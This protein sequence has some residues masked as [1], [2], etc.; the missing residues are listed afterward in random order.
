MEQLTIFALSVSSLLS[1]V[2]WSLHERQHKK[3]R[4]EERRS[5]VANSITNAI[6]DHRRMDAKPW[7]G[8]VLNNY[9]RMQA[10]GV[11]LVT[12]VGDTDV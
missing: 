3:E 2:R 11:P 8:T 6:T 12:R 7:A 9:S 4:D 5:R 1:W 10:E